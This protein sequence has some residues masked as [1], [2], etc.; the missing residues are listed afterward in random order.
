[1]TPRL[2]NV[3][4][5]PTGPFRCIVADPPWDYPEGFAS[6]SR[7]AGVWEGDVISKPLPYPSMTLAEIEALPVAEVAGPDSRLWLWTTN[8][9]LPASFGVMA[10]W[11]F[12]YRQTLVWHKSDGNM[13]GSVAPNSAEFLLVG[14][15][16]Q[17]GR[18]IKL[19]S[20]VWKFP[21][22][23]R[24]SKKPE[25]WQ[26]MIEQ[27]DEGPYLE[28]FA[29]QPRIGW[30]VWGNEVPCKANPS[31]QGTTHLVRRT[32]DGVVGSLDSEA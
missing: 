16:G 20:A 13:G 2:Q 1:M 10:A 8:R 21:Q 27:V 26:D 11:G 30:T 4:G 15:R 14:V 12:N 24:H 31:H 29:R 3:V 6:Q 7:T 9:Y 22:G 5:L 19:S 25:A 17:P 32:L 18:K 23:K 28:M